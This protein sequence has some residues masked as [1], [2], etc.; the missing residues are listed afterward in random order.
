M[1]APIDLI[2]DTPTARALSGHAVDEGVTLAVSPVCKPKK[3]ITVDP[4]D[5]NAP[6]CKPGRYIVAD[7]DD[8]NAPTCSGSKYIV[9]PD[10]ARRKSSAQFPE[11]AR[12]FGETL[13]E[14]KR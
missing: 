8:P 10:P 7:P 9:A 5:P 4:D 6:T 14:S 3:Y 1:T 2:P 12:E 13:A 11:W